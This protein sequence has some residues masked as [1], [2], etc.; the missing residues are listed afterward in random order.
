MRNEVHQSMDYT[1]LCLD[2]SLSDGHI[3][4]TQQILVECRYHSRACEGKD[5]EDSLWI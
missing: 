1:I 2:D 4:G 3:V 5:E